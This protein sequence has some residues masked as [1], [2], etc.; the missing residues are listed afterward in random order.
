MIVNKNKIVP[1]VNL[2]KFKIREGSLEIKKGPLITHFN[3]CSKHCQ[4]YQ[5]CS[6]ILAFDSNQLLGSVPSEFLAE[7]SGKLQIMFLFLKLLAQEILADFVPE[8]FI[9]RIFFRI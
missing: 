1:S 9:I 6:S 3:F 7:I 2:G 5:L 8:F 4:I